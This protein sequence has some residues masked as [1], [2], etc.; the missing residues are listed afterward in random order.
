MRDESLSRGIMTLCMAGAIAVLGVNLQWQHLSSFLMT[1][2]MA[3]VHQQRLRQGLRQAKIIAKPTV[4]LVVDLSDRRVY[5]YSNLT[6]NASYDL[7]VGQK[8]WETP[9]GTFKVLTMQENP[10]WQHPI[11]GKTIPP[12]P[13]NPLGARWIKFTSQDYLEIGFHGTEQESSI[14][15]AVSHGCLRL[16]NRDIVQLYQLVSPGTPVVVRL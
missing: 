3:G 12:G 14:G 13:G 5:V 16:R 11:T 15:K 4:R 10:T 9:T 6:L 7:A 2:V 1:D 8:G